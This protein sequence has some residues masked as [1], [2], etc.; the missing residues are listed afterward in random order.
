VRYELEYRAQEETKVHFGIEF[1][2]YPPLL[3]SGEGKIEIDGQSL[4]HRKPCE[5]SGKTLSLIHPELSLTISLH[6]KARFFLFPVQTVS[7][8]EK[9][10]DLTIQGLAVM[11]FWALELKPGKRVEKELKIEMS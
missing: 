11:P 9:G 2:L 8:S 1:N 3:A 4:D 7:Q 6:E 5:F 10:F